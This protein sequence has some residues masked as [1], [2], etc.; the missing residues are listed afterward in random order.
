MVKKVDITFYVDDKANDINF[1][2]I[3]KLFAKTFNTNFKGI[4]K[5]EVENGI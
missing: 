1:W 2:Q 5:M 3:R 4:T